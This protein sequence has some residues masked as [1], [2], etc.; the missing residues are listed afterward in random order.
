MRATKSEKR[1]YFLCIQT[2]FRFY[3]LRN[4]VSIATMLLEALQYFAVALNQSYA[5]SRIGF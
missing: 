4:Y 2:R 1:T 3:F 5:R